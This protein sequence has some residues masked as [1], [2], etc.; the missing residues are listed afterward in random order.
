MTTGEKIRSVRKEKGLTQ[1]ALGALLGV[2]QATVGQYE[3]NPNPPKI[4]TLRRI[5]GAL[6]VPVG[7]L[8]GDDVM[9]YP[10][11]LALR[12]KLASVG[13][14]FEFYEEDAMLWVTYP[15]GILEVTEEELKKLNDEADSY[16]RFKLQELR[17]AH[18]TRF[19]RTQ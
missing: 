11:W 4:E 15:D 14:S 13:C 16:L 9:R 8:L 5:A 17:E 12:Y 10:W 1:K 7:L 19:R 3:T 6:E 2:T 18:T